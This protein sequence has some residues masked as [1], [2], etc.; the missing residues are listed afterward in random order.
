MHNIRTYFLFILTITGK[1]CLEFRK[2]RILKV[3]RLINGK[4]SYQRKCTLKFEALLTR[5]PP[6]AEHR[7]FN[8]NYL[9]Y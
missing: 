9:G 2:K 8:E 1:K 6:E 3:L 7:F 5:E 4:I